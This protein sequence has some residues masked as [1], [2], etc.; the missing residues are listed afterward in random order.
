MPET[1]LVKSMALSG[2]PRKLSNAAM[3]LSVLHRLGKS[4]KIYFQKVAGHT[5]IQY[6]EE[7]DKLAKLASG[8]TK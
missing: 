2:L 5:G 1:S 4:I 7:A 6:N 3:R 8:V